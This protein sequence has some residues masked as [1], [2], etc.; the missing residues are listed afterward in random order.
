MKT[1]S[2]LGYRWNIEVDFIAHFGEGNMIKK[3][4]YQ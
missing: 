1:R 2:I 3:N 4:L